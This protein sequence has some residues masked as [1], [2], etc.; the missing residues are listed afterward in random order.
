LFAADGKNIGEE[1]TTT[2]SGKERG[3]KKNDRAEG[4]GRGQ[5]I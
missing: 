1:E 5:K 3:R 4:T 2:E